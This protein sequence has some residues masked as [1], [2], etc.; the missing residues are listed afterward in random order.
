MKMIYIVIGVFFFIACTK[1]F[2]QAHDRADEMNA[3]QYSSFVIQQGAH[4]CDQNPIKSITT[5][6]MKFMVKFD[7]SAMYETLLRENQYAVNKL[8]GF[9]EGLNN[10]D[11]S[12][13]I[14]WS[15]NQ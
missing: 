4:Y 15:W 3:G 10:H 2:G 7:S 13:R 8:W 6:E 9:S 11:N 5:S 1:N 14:G 12:A